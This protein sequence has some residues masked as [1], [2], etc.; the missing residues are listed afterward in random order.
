MN[1]ESKVGT[2]SHPLGNYLRERPGDGTLYRV[3]KGQVAVLKRQ[4]EEAGG[5]SSLIPNYDE[6]IHGLD[7]GINVLF[8]SFGREDRLGIPYATNLRLHREV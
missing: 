5:M 6:R 1:S 4:I 7:S 2:I 3:E 8:E